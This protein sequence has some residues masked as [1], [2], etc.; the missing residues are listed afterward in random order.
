MAW[1]GQTTHTYETQHVDVP[2][3]AAAEVASWCLVGRLQ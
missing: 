1:K 2:A 3:A